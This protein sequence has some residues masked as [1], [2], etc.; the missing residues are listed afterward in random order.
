MCITTTTT[1]NDPNNN[2]N[3]PTKGYQGKK[4]VGGNSSLG[5]KIFDVSSRDAIHQYAD[6]IKAIADYAGQ[7][8]THG[9]DIRFMIENLED[10]NFVRPENP[11]NEN[12]TFEMESWKKQLDIYWKRRGVYAD[13][14]MKLYSLVWGQSTKTTQ[15]KLETHAEFNQCKSTYDSLKLLKIIREFVFKSDDR[16]YKYKAEDQ[17]KRNYY[18]LRQTPDMSCQEYFEKVR[19][20]TEVIK[21]LGGSLVD[22]MHLRDELPEREPRGGFTAQVIAEAKGR[23]QDKTIAYGLLV[24]ADRGRYG[25]LIEEIENDFLKGHDDYPKTP[26]EAYNLL[27]NYRNYNNPQKRSAAQGGL[28]QVAF[29]VDGKRTKLDGSLCKY[30]HIKCFKCGEF[31]HY[32][33]DCPEKE[34]S[35]SKI[36]NTGEQTEV[37]MTTLQVTLSVIKTE[38]SPMWILCDNESTVDIFKNR[39]ILKNIKTSNKPIRLKGIDGNTIEVKEE[40]ELLGYGTV[41]YHPKVTANIISFFNLARRYKSV[42]YDSKVKDAF[43]VTRDDGSMLEFGPSPEGLYY[44]DFLKSVK[45]Q[46]ER[47]MIVNTVEELQRNYTRR[48]RE[49]AD[50][51][52]R[53]YAVVGRPSS[54]TFRDMLNRGLILNNPVTENDYKNAISIYG[55]DL[56][57]TKGKTIRS[58]PEHVSVNLSSTPKERRDIV[59]SVDLMH[60]ME[61]SF[62]VTVVRDVRFITVNA[63]PDRKKKTILNAM[64][65]VIN[66]FRG[67]GHKLEEMELSE[68]H[69]PVHTILADNEFAALR[70]DL[71]S[72]GIRLNIASK[73]EHVPEVE[74]QIR[75]IKERAR[76][77]VQTLP[78]SKMPN[79]MKIAMIGYVVYWLNAMPKHDQRLSPRDIIMGEEKLDYKKVCQLPFGAYVQVHD[80]LDIT[81]TMESRTTG[82]INL[83]PTGN[84][85]G[86]HRFLSLKTGEL[87][88]RRRWTELPVP[89]DVIHRVEEMAGE[90]EDVLRSLTDVE[91]DDYDHGD[92]NDDTAEED[93]TNHD[94]VD[95]EKSNEEN[96]TEIVINDEFGDI[97]VITDETKAIH[98]ESINNN[99]EN[100]PKESRHETTHGYNLRENRSRDYSHR[101]AFL[102]VNAGLKRWGDRAREALMD[103]LKLFLKENVFEK[104]NEP[105]STQKKSALRLHC[106]I[107]KKRDGKIKARAVADGRTQERYMEEETYSP[108]VRLESIMLSTLIDAYEKRHVRT[109]DI[110]GA[111]LKA[112]V[113][114][115]LEL[116]VKMEGDLAILMNQLSEEFKIDQ[117]GTMYLKCVKA[118]YGHVEAARLF[119]NDLHGSLTVKL[120]FT[121]NGYDPC[122]YNKKT[123]EGVVTIRTHVDDLKL[124]SKSEKELLKV[125]DNLREIYQEITV[126]EGTSHDYL[127]MI[128]T[129]NL[130][131]QCVTINMENYIL[132]CI[133]CFEEEVSDERLRSANT[134]AS[135]YLFKTRK[136]K[137]GVK[138]TRKKT[139]LFHSTVA[140]LLFVAKRA[141]PDILLTVSF[142]TTRVKCP[143]QDDWKKL[144]RLL[145]YLKGSADLYLTLSCSNLSNLTW[146]IDGSYASH[147]DMRG[148]SG[149]ML[150]AGDCAVLFRSNKQKVNT[151]SSTETELVAVDD[152]LP[153][154][155]WTKKFMHDQGYDLETIIKEDNRSTILLM[156]NG[157]LSSGKRT[158]HLDVRY[159]YV[160]DL[161]ERG[162][163]SV[164]H[165]VSDDMIAD[166]LENSDNLTT[167]SNAEFPGESVTEGSP[168]E[169]CVT[170]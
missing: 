121:Q 108:T 89:S 132:A 43:V 131:K 130:D 86:T 67:R 128:M 115:D 71:D 145:G 55:K 12:N 151:R 106:F 59:L 124:S 3:N 169:L 25:K 81:N 14:K 18:N 77:I 42:V 154:I 167:C 129:H 9:G 118:L 61:L 120:G 93:V 65:Q 37:T 157:K 164:K 165:C 88:A 91:G 17:A 39:N 54:E 13:N 38:I 111:F 33:S 78:Y 5:G 163:L 49:G 41:Y 64:S 139:K 73:E 159:F 112:K 155:Q 26:T 103:E 79:K 150:L 4:F 109:V 10:Y 125:I 104:L 11:D 83:G 116:I 113:P 82:A 134:P 36:N 94:T 101:F 149:A 44:Y 50:R 28:D 34:K 70:Q 84:L 160:K 35:K 72:H 152:A 27:V 15:S 23:I 47:T 161:I 45:R 22:E 31:G 68:C 142:L 156:K 63:I 141:R 144:M 76:S 51:A 90:S 146:Y 58:K 53:L 85:Q 20:I 147:E 8:Y 98:E 29:V 66:L 52:R 19:N 133:E 96:I 48:E 56:G 92:Q 117:H 6:T 170:E 32:K 166:L 75:V 158:K 137:G 123:D 69:N 30:P 107:I 40:G 135:S 127:G 114:D 126:H 7:A 57:T 162:V 143:D 1:Q 2:K 16:Q 138:L 119:Y 136:D 153:T 168:S 97:G 148:Q 62:L 60:I 110:K 21:S 46:E 100:E 122:V 87:L 24:R 74:R 95:G 80:D 105:N 99:E 140:K 102:S